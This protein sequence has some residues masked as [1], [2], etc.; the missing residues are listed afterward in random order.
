MPPAER[1]L[2]EAV[3]D[4]SLRTSF[5]TPADK[6]TLRATFENIW[7]DYGVQARPARARLL[8]RAQPR[9]APSQPLLALHSLRAAARRFGEAPAPF[10]ACTRLRSSPWAGMYGC[11]GCQSSLTRFAGSASG[12][13]RRRVCTSCTTPAPSRLSSASSSRSRACRLARRRM[14]PPW[15]IS[16]PPCFARADAARRRS[17]RSYAIGTAAHALRAPNRQ[18]RR[19]AAAHA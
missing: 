11:A 2:S 19:A 14:R 1:E 12:C 3:P 9:T 13:A 17:R 4:E 18:P 10:F 5:I 7:N 8:H 15:G 16:A 6:D